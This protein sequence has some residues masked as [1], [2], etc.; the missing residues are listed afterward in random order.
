MILYG[1]SRIGG[2]LSRSATP[3]SRKVAFRSRIRA[4]FTFTRS[5]LLFTLFRSVFTCALDANTRGRG[6]FT[7]GWMGFTLVYDIYSKLSKENPSSNVEGL[8]L[9]LFWSRY[10]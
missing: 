8:D 6:M 3:L 10:T 2:F 7:L 9:H 5:R 1:G 4:N